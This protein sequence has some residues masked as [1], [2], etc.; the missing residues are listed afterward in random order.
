[1][2]EYILKRRRG[3][4]TIRM[5]YN[6]RGE[7]IVSASPLVSQKRIDEFVSANSA[8]IEK[9]K[10]TFK[11]HS[12]S[13]G[14]TIPYLGK[15]CLLLVANGAENTVN[16]LDGSILVMTKRKASEQKVRTMLRIFYE[17]TI[18]ETALPRV[19]FWC[20][21]MGLA[22]PK[23]STCN[24]KTRWAVCVPSSREIRFSAISATLDYSMIDMIVVHELCHLFHPNHSKQFW[25][26][27][28]KYVPDIREKEKRL[29]EISLRGAHRNLF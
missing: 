21:V 10:A 14:D 26:E 24:A 11:D 6:D 18:L 29:R 12:Y 1:M 27:V 2:E 8:W 19:K 4:K 28:A 7:L 20:S 5:H 3:Q 22:E 13:N 16:Y 25:E 9:T 15:S 17:K 23:V